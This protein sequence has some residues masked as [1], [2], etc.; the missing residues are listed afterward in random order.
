MNDKLLKADEEKNPNLIIEVMGLEG[1]NQEHNIVEV[2]HDKNHV[3]YC[4]FGTLVYW[5][6]SA[7]PAYLTTFIPD[8]DTGSELY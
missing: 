5:G 4:V 6:L 8:Y 7:A 3:I 2:K 1:G